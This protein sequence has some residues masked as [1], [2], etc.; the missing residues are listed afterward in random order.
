MRFI[1]H[2]PDIGE[3][4][5][6][7]KILE[8]YVEKG[9]SVKEG[10]H[11]VKMETDKVVTDIPSPRDGVVIQLFGHEGDVINVDDALVELDI[12]GAA[13][14]EAQQIAEIKPK[15]K[16][17]AG[18]AEPG[19]GVVGSLEVAGDAAFLPASGEGL[20]TTGKTEEKAKGKA[21]A[22]PVARAMAKDLGIDINLVKGTGPAGRVMK[23][24]ILAHRDRK[25]TGAAGKTISASV[26]EKDSSPA[27]E[28]EE[29]SQIRK[30]IARQMSVS[31]NTAAH[32]TVYEEVDISSLKELRRKNKE[33]FAERGAK[34]TYMP[35]IVKALA[36]SLK[37]YKSLNA[38]LDLENNRVIYKYEYNIGMAVD[39]PDGL[40][41]PVI[42]DA[43]KKGI[44]ELAKEIEDLA[45]RARDRA[46]NLNEVRGGTFSITN[47]GAIA[48]ISRTPVLNYPEEANLRNG[49][50]MD[51][52]VIRNGELAVGTILPLSLTVDHRLIDGG[53]AV[54]FLSSIMAFLADPVSLLLL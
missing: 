3:G 10:E 22:T 18:V 13:G 17:V 33:K 53:E 26:P 1:F 7:G 35:F 11:L 27:V 28:Y 37:R 4:I 45:A 19:F 46:L 42:R 25:A 39:A 34:L 51:R 21:R 29:L 20:E 8:W 47:Y 30:A 2:F 12:E 5:T 16:T 31:K 23:R 43:D 36:E 52:P 32:M 15:G 54:R 50:I 24:D 9:Q 40:V 38:Q 14:E 48:G 6:E 44:Y 49:R 41:V